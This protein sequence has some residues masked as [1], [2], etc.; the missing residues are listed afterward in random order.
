MVKVVIYDFG[1]GGELFAEYLERELPVLKV[2]RVID[3]ENSDLNSTNHFKTRR[4]VES[5]LQPYLGRVD[6]II[7]ANHF[8]TQIGLRYLERKYKNQKFIGFHLPT[9]DTFVNRDT[10]I[11]TTSAIS[12]SLA[13]R[14]YLHKIHRTSF[15][16]A[17][18]D[19]PTLID[20]AAIESDAIDKIIAGAREQKNFH[21][22][23]FIIINSHFAFFDPY[24]RQHK[25]KVHTS[26]Y[27]ALNE[28]YTKLKI[29]GRPKNKHK[30][31]HK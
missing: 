14:L 15:T 17:L 5:S 29:R 25:M 26:Y 18:D 21:P 7:I 6:L 12:R 11:L 16:I 24:F 10:L 8:L 4:L 23:E 13:Y 31:R 28:V 22:K 3:W 27:E 1:M 19:W 20:D 9:L 30:P 2:I